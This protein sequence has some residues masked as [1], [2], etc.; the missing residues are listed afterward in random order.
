MKRIVTIYHWYRKDQ[1]R[2]DEA[3]VK[4][5]GRSGKDL[6][7]GKNGQLSYIKKKR[8]TLLS[9]S[10]SGL[11]GGGSKGAGEKGNKVE[12]DGERDIEMGA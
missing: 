11:L 7:V 4:L 3:L 6:E 12:P 5:F 8:S 2:A 10:L 1:E 9:G